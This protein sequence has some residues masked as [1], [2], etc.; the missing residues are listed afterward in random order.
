MKFNSGFKGLIQIH[1]NKLFPCWME[2]T[3]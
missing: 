3:S 2:S 1:K